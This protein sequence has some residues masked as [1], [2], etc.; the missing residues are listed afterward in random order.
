LSHFDETTRRRQPS[1]V[2][3]LQSV[4]PMRERHL[5]LWTLLDGS[6]YLRLREVLFSVPAMPNLE[7]TGYYDAH[8][9]SLLV[10]LLFDA[11]EHQLVAVQLWALGKDIGLILPSRWPEEQRWQFATDIQHYRCTEALPAHRPIVDL[12]RVFQSLTKQKSRSTR[13]RFAAESDVGSPLKAAFTS[14]LDENCP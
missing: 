4:P 10:S 5:F 11:D 1:L 6:G 14:Y 3:E 13:V 9:R 7:A 8:R 12:L 2:P